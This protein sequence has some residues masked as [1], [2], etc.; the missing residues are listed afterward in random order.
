[1]TPL[2]VLL[3]LA[4]AGP[5]VAGLTD[6]DILNF[7]LNL[8]YLEAEFYTCATTG[9]GLPASLRGGG[10]PS[11]GCQKANL[12]GDVQ[13]I[14]NE[15]ANDERD[16]VTFLRKALGASAVPM[17]L[18]NIGIGSNGSFSMAADAALNQTLSPPFSPYANDL[19]FLHGAFI[20]EDVGVTAYEGAAADISNKDY[21]SAAAGILG[22]EAYHAGSIREQLIQNSSFVVQP[23]GVEVNAIVGAISALRAKLSGAADDQGILLDGA[24]NLVPTDSNSITFHRNISQVLAI[25]TG[26]GSG[27]KGLFFPNGLNSA[28]PAAP[29]STAGAAASTGRKLLQTANLVAV[30]A[31][32]SAPAPMSPPASPPAMPAITDTDILNFALNLEYLEAQFYS[33]SVFGHGIPAQ[34]TGGNSV[35]SGAKKATLSAPV[36]ALAMEIAQDEL[37]HVIFLRKTL[38][39]AAVP[40]P[41][42]NLGDAFSKAA[43]A[44]VGMTLM[45]PFLPYSGDIPFLLGAFIFEDVGV[46][47]YKGAAPLISDK[48]YITPAAG[49]LAVEAYHSGA[50]RTLLFQQA[51]TPI[52]PYGVN[53]STITGAISVLRD[54][55]SGSPN[56]SDDENIISSSGSNIVPTDGNSIVFSRT[57]A[58]VINIAVL[59]NSTGIGGFF[60]SGLNGVINGTMASIGSVASLDMAPPGNAGR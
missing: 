27:G 25:V 52:A 45:P 40:M 9:V 57:P 21:L 42:L 50:V 37:N 1:M 31:P 51:G 26:G 8:E 16:H 43:D 54:K 46:T 32:V 29:V 44:A 5:L 17:P 22:V 60:P 35:V 34:Y 7:A 55:A 36:M 48:T 24:P 20:F 14:A 53:V 10:P 6:T 28:P 58:Q 2:F 41:D 33:W 56:P 38:G 23:Y 47:A 4:L 11:I 15:I 59:G 13:I 30:P 39:P 19:F 12:T 3:S 49:I 18:I